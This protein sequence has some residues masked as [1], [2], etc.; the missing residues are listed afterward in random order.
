MTDKRYH[1]YVSTSYVEDIREESLKL[2]YAL[3]GLGAFPWQFH[4]HRNLLNNAVARRQIDECDLV[5]FLLGGKYGDLSSA[6]VSYMQM[7]FSYALGKRKPI[8][9][10]LQANP[11]KLPLER[12]ET[13]G[14]QLKKYLNFR[15]Q[16][17]RESQFFYEYQNQID[18]ER[19]TKQLFGQAVKEMQDQG[20]MRVKVDQTT[21]SELQRLRH[22]VVKL[23]KQLVKV[24]HEHLDIDQHHSSSENVVISYRTH[25]YQDGNLKE[26]RLQYDTDLITL[27]R[28]LAASFKNPNSEHAFQTILNHHLD[29]LALESARAVMPRAHAVS[30][31]QIDARSLQQVKLQMKWNNWI[32]PLHE[33]ETGNRVRWQ[34]TPEAQKQLN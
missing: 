30:R 22:K 6:G 23:E 7:D 34:L 21:P 8:I 13:E 12:Q 9:S 31:T 24:N 20:W 26:I 15:Q 5:I 19:H 18:L 28:I 32:I 16:L 17:K 11:E 1:V 25:A 2:E 3:L 27:L 14:D 4:E 29:Q 10:L 33:D